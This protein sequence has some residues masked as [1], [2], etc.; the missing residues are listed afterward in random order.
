[1]NAKNEGAANNTQAVHSETN[2]MRTWCNVLELRITMYMQCGRANQRVRDCGL[3]P[4]FS[5]NFIEEYKISTSRELVF[6]V[7]TY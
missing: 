7:V 1:M 6:N 5:M 3:A 4:G 2:A